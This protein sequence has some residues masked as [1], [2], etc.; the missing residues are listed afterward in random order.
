MPDSNQSYP[1]HVFKA[2]SPLL[3]LQERDDIGR[4][5]DPKLKMDL[6]PALTFNLT[7]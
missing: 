2:G 3:Q 7:F 4:F 6:D 1:K 5:L